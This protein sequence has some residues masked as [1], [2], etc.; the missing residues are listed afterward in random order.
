MWVF[1]VMA[2]FQPLSAVGGQGDDFL[3]TQPFG[4]QPV[5]NKELVRNGAFNQYDSYNKPVSWVTTGT[6]SAVDPAGSHDGGPAMAMEA[7]METRA[8]LY[9]ELRLPTETTAA[10]FSFDFRL[11]PTYGGAAQLAASIS[12]YSTVI[13]NVLD[14]GAVYADTGWY[15]INVTLSAA[16]VAAIQ[17]AHAAGQAVYV[18]FNLLQNPANAFRA[19]VDNVAFKVSGT[20]DIP[21]LVGSI[22]YVGL[23]NGH[24]KTVKRINPDGSGNRTLWTHP[25]AITLTN[26]IHDA[27]WKPDA[28]EVAF[29]S[30]HESA[31]SAFHS[32][33]YGIGPEGEGLRRITNPPSKAELDAG[34]Y[35]WGG[36]S[37]TIHNNYGSVT[38]FQI[39]IE[40]A[41]DA[42]SV[43]VGNYGDT[44]AYTV[45]NVADLGVGLHYVVFTWADGGHANCKEYAAAVVDVQ[46]GQ[47]VNNVDLSF[48]GTCGTYNSDSISWKRDGT[49]VGVDVITPRK[50][51]AAGQAIGTDLFSSPTLADE[52]AWSPV[53]TQIL[54]RSHTFDFATSGIYLTTEGGGAGTRLI[55]EHNALWATPAWLPDASGFVFSLD[56]YLY[57]YTLASSQVI[58]LA[59]FYNDYV[60][61]PSVSPDGN[62]VVFEWQTGAT[63]AHDLWILDRR[64]PVEMWALTSDGQSSNPD[65][66]RQNPPSA[67]CTGLTAVAI[68]G[69]TTGFTNTTMSFTA[70]FTPADATQPI[71][72]T[73]TPAPLSG[74]STASASYT[75]ANTGDQTIQVN[76]ENCGGLRSD[77]HT[78]TIVATTQYI[79]LPL[80]IR[81]A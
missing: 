30:N 10:T 66:S 1:L 72:Y 49:E 41:Q 25:S 61:N 26:A 46:P 65:W 18:I 45:P 17:S 23:E 58:T 42:V 28:S 51:A 62:Y 67:S 43:N 20:M 14:T 21:N 79:Y 31:Y 78:V 48:S 77:T 37:G 8:D 12:T 22:A 80:V 5:L 73:W 57:E 6:G 29:S 59:Y 64:N 39:Y 16:D 38:I 52:L 13:T 36:V 54:Y 3:P 24:P 7:I 34:G 81:N 32:D 76:V 33:V 35:Q 44:V 63:L 11:L 74:Q 68:S 70:A 55:N 71:T 19:Y 15:S 60:F 4:A 9:Q 56:H 50:F 40:G 53:D 2:L 27:A 47:T 69:P 75:W